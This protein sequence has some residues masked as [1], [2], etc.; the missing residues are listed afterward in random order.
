MISGDEEGTNIC[1]H[2]EDPESKPEDSEIFY[3]ID[4]EDAVMHHNNNKRIGASSLENNG[5]SE[6][7]Q[8][9]NRQSQLENDD[10]EEAPE[11]GDEDDGVEQEEL[12]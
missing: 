9:L 7:N 6:R 1:K 2:T 12:P 4:E 10:K 8:G 11:Q 3:S 5:I